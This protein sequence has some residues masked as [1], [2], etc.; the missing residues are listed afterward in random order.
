[1]R[2]GVETCNFLTERQMRAVELFSGPSSKILPCCSYSWICFLGG[3][4]ISLIAFLF[5]ASIKSVSPLYYILCVV[6]IQASI[7]WTI[8]LSFSDLTPKTL[9]IP[10]DFSLYKF[11]RSRIE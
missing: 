9:S 2:S 6:I 8:A 3:C 7:S 11:C 4:L 1:M 10:V 5:G